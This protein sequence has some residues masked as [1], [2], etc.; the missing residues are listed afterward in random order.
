[1]SR[2]DEIIGQLDEAAKN[3]KKI[4]EEYKKETG[5]G[6]VGVMPLYAP[7]ELIH[8][9]GYLP[10]GIW[11]GREIISRAR[12]YLPPFACSIMQSIME[13]ETEGGYDMLDAVLF[14]VPCDTLKCMSQ[15]WKGS[16][17]VIVFTHPQ[18]RKLES[19]NRFLVTE[20]EIVKKKLEEILKVRIRD[21]DITRSIEIYNENRR[22]MREFSDVAA[23]HPEL[24]D[25]VKRHI[26]M[27]S[28]WFMEK[29]RHS[30]L[31][32]E[33]IAELKKLPASNF[34][35]KKVILTGIMAEPEELLRIFKEEKIAVAADD[36]AQ[37]SRQFRHDVPEAATP[38]LRLAKWWQDLEGCALATD[39]KKIRGQLLMDMVKK[40]GAEAV[41]ICMM[42]FCDPEEFDYPIYYAEFEKA[43]IRNLMVEV[44]LE[45]TA[46][47]QTKTRV[48]TFIETL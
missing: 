14:S 30:A 34:D 3:P 16:S 9:A 8:A 2:I 11:G 13:L 44:D 37:E 5:K 43:G 27:K 32:K 48:Q 29:G 10:M 42:K 4:I 31:V 41:I 19:A 36:L 22:T 1:M 23:E 38:L 20:Y 46:F 7:E 24:I 6:V 40:H 15:K 21:E 39:V 17:P 12:A 45:M 47:E 33:L 18:N 35:G 28:R 25:P 26:V